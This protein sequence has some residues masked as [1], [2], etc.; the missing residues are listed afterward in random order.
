M[1]LKTDERDAFWFLPGPVCSVG[2]SESYAMKK[3]LA[4]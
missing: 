2:T 3:Q 1:D 4:S